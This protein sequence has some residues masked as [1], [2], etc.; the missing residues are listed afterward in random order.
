MT[1]NDF[2]TIKGAISGWDGSERRIRDRR[3]DLAGGK[4]KVEL[5]RLERRRFQY[6]HVCGRQ[7]QPTPT[8]K[9]I[10][11]DCRSSALRMGA[12][13]GWFRGG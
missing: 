8:Q 12:S 13:A 4:P 11:P 2:S 10:C 7:F 9:Q 5:R 1:A 6:C 3:A